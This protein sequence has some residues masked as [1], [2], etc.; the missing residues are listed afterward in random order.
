MLKNFEPVLRNIDSYGVISWKQLATFS[1][2]RCF[3][4]LEFL[5]PPVSQTSASNWLTMFI[6]KEIF[7]SSRKRRIVKTFEPFTWKEIFS[8]RRRRS[9]VKIYEPFFRNMTSKLA[10]S[11]QL[12]TRFRHITCF[13]FLCFYEHQSDKPA[14]YWLLR[15]I[16]KEIFLTL[17]R[18]SIIKKLRVVFENQN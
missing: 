8:S 11:C 18:E 7:S 15:L 6:W 2:L 13:L 10:L 3:Q 1:Y 12:L 5:R 16:W 17:C 9:I 4:I 14:A